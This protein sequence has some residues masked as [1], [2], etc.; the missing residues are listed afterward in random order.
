MKKRVLFLIESLSGGGAEKVLSVLVQH[1][2]G[3]EHYEINVCPIVDTGPYRET[4]LKSASRYSPVI[5]SGGGP[6]I[7]AFNRIKYKLVYSW[8]PMRWVYRFYIPKDNDVEIAFCEGYVT[9][10]LS[11]SKS[12]AK[13]IAWVHTDLAANPWPLQQEI[14]DNK[15]EERKSYLCFD[16]IVCVSDSVASVMR[17]EYG[18]NHTVV[19]HNPVDVEAL[20][21]LARE[22]S[23][24]PMDPSCFNIVALGRLV[25]LKGFDL[26]IKTV[27]ELIKDFTDIRLYIVG[28]G[29]ERARLQAMIAACHTQE[30]ILLTGYLT[31]PY[32]LLSRADLYVCPSRAEGFSLT[33]AEAMV[34]DIPIVSMNSAGPAEL[35]EQGKFGTICR[36]GEDLSQ[37]LRK[38]IS[39]PEYLAE[40]RRMSEA[41]KG[42]F[43]VETVLERFENVLDLVLR[44]HDSNYAG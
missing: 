35:L 23:P 17:R 16:R 36:S 27:A 19:I 30:N 1:L 13:K 22:A 28:E 44:N 43:N 18:V 8:L 9:K 26:L 4:V 32:A 12:K 42:R 31:N 15:E 29:G 25:P 24:V 20:S 40:L 37:A 21:A 14:F 41:G 38:A 5:R 33:V 6:I 34:L 39:N 11:Q 7:R 3:N 2:K 10:L